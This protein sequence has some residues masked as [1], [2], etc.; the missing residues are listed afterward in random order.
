[1]THTN[2]RRLLTGKKRQLHNQITRPK[3]H[4]SLRGR[5]APDPSGL[6]HRSPDLDGVM[7]KHQPQ[8]NRDWWAWRDPAVGA[9]LTPLGV[10]GGHEGFEVTELL[11]LIGV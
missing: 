1:M 6:L 8:G 4:C 2:D 7:P 3:R 9:H 11:L 10:D 5:S